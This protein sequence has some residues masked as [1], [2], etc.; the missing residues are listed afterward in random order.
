MVW[1]PTCGLTL[2]SP[3]KPP[4][5]KPWGGLRTFRTMYNCWMNETSKKILTGKK[6]KLLKWEFNR[7]D[8]EKYHIKIMYETQ[9]CTCF[10]NCF[11]YYSTSTEKDSCCSPHTV[12]LISPFVIN[13]LPTP[14]GWSG[15]RVPYEIENKAKLTGLP[16]NWTCDPDLIS[17]R[18]QLARH[19]HGGGK[20]HPKCQESSLHL[21]QWDS[22]RQKSQRL[23]KTFQNEGNPECNHSGQTVS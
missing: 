13:D 16:R 21:S 20:L 4:S 12:S 5:Y 11:S 6:P 18:E 23:F 9:V 8:K 15:Q 3:A 1:S 2:F 22:R 7:N 14:D 19:K 17:S 10:W